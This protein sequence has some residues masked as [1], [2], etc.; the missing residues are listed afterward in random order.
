[1]NISLN[2]QIIVAGNT[3]EGAVQNVTKDNIL[4]LSCIPSGSIVLFRFFNVLRVAALMQLKKVP[5][6]PKIL[7][8]E[9]IF[10]GSYSN[11]TGNCKSSPALPNTTKM[12]RRNA[13][14]LDQKKVKSLPSPSLVNNTGSF[15]YFRA[16]PKPPLFLQAMLRDFLIFLIV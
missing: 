2:Q 15:R 8:A 6:S 11:G 1:M 16:K 4:N 14:G 7:T 3:C 5:I 13:G 9:V 10:T 12:I